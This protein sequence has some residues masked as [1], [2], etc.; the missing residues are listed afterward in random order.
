MPIQLSR[1]LHLH[2]FLK[3]FWIIGHKLWKLGIR[4]VSF[5]QP[6]FWRCLSLIIVRFKS[7][8]C[9]NTLYDKTDR[10][11]YVPFDNVDCFRKFP[12]SF[13]G[14][15]RWQNSQSLPLHNEEH[16]HQ[17]DPQMV[18][19][20]SQAVV[21][22]SS[23]PMVQH[24][25]SMSTRNNSTCS[26]TTARAEDVCNRDPPG[27][28]IEFSDFVG[29]TSVEFERYERN[30][31]SYVLTT[32]HYISKSRILLDIVRELNLTISRSHHCFK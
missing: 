30:F 20:T 9:R 23:T 16:Y 22:Y 3:R 11:P 18:P 12:I 15:G 25:T 6:F 1:L 14:T 32:D 21:P 24:D 28:S 27:R 2:N 5:L 31:T 19:S 8:S 29:V 26:S 10:L 13:F 17:S 7:K 4:Q